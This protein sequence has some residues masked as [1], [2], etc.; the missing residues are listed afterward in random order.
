MSAVFVFLCLC[1]EDG[2]EGGEVGSEYPALV[3]EGL[4][5]DLGA[6]AGVVGG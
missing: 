4:G 2:G 6:I 3:G 1:W 5:L